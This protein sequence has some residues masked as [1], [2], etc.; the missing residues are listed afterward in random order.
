VKP[1]P[2]KLR[3]VL[4]YILFLLVTLFTIIFPFHFM[5]ISHDHFRRA[6][7]AD[8]ARLVRYNFSCMQV[9]TRPS[10]TAPELPDYLRPNEITLN[11]MRPNTKNL[12]LTVIILEKSILLVSCFQTSKLTP[13]RGHDRQLYTLCCGR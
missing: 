5:G 3:S 10:S 13:V 12:A 2:T 4:I 11:D 1:V 7:D 8:S 6:S 9:P